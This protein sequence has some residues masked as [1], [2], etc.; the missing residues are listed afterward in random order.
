MKLRWHNTDEDT[1]ARVEDAVRH[2]VELIDVE[3]PGSL[4]FHH[5]FLTKDY[6]GPHVFVWGVEGDDSFHCKYHDKTEWKTSAELDV[7]RSS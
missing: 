1:I 2:D 5:V 7:E 4:I 6:D 3:D